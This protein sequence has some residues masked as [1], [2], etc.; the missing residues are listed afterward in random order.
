MFP[1]SLSTLKQENLVVD[2]VSNSAM[3]LYKPLGRK[4]H[5]Q[6]SQ[7]FSYRTRVR[8]LKFPPWCSCLFPGNDV[9]WKVASSI[10]RLGHENSR[11]PERAWFLLLPSEN[12]HWKRKCA[13]H[14]CTLKIIIIKIK[15]KIFLCVNNITTYIKTMIKILFVSIIM[16]LYEYG[17]KKSVSILQKRNYAPKKIKTLASLKI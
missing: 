10:S 9:I 2:L 6:N 8:T 1:K 5:I 17:L 4:K 13:A 16:M 11:C 15:N 14:K 7:Q 3:S 12:V